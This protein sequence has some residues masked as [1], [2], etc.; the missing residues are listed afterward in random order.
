MPFIQPYIFSYFSNVL[1]KKYNAKILG[2]YNFK[3]IVSKLKETLIE[4]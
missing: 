1:A 4:N 2:F 3:L